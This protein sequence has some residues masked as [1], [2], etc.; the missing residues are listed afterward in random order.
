MEQGHGEGV[1]DQSGVDGIGHGPADD[2]SA[3]EIEN[4][5][6]EKPAFAG[7]DV[8]DVGHPD[9]VGRGGLRGLGQAVGSDGVVVVAIG[10]A[11]AVA[12]LL[13]TAQAH[14]VHDAGDAFASMAASVGTEGGLDARAPVGAT[15]TGVDGL[16]LDGEVLVLESAGSGAD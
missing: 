1:E 13:A 14:G 7:M 3:E 9:L 16:D 4:G 12:A 11:D 10:G 8:G 6:E 2:L 5:G 15:A